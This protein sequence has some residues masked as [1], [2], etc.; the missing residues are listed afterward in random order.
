MPRRV[1][2]KPKAFYF[3]DLCL[4]TPDPLLEKFTDFETAENASESTAKTVVSLS[5]AAISTNSAG[6]VPDSTETISQPDAWRSDSDT[7]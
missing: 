5:R 3:A 1:K 4:N 2:C 6:S 7:V